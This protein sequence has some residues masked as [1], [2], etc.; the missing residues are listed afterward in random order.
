[1]VGRKR[2][3]ETKPEEEPPTKS[4]P[5]DGV[6][7]SKREIRKPQVMTISNTRSAPFSEEEKRIIFNTLHKSVLFCKRHVGD[8]HSLMM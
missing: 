3:A 4:S 7:R 6:R 8:F 2:K 5:P 1:M